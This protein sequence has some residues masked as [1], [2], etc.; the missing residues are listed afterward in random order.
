MPPQNAHYAAQEVPNSIRTGPVEPTD[1][2]EALWCIQ[3]DLVSLLPIVP[4]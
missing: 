1:G 3:D 4:L 2:S